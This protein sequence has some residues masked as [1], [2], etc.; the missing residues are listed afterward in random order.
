MRWPIL[1][2]ILLCGTLS[3]CQLFSGVGK[4][5]SQL[6][7]VHDCDVRLDQNAIVAGMDD[8]DTIERVRVNPDCTTE[9]DFQQS[10]GEKDRTHQFQPIDSQEL[11]P[12]EV[13]E[14][15]DGVEGAGG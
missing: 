3:G 13:D 4:D 14:T 6:R 7:V 10:V 11:A 2:L 15:G 1:L 9:I 5:G 12:A 8:S